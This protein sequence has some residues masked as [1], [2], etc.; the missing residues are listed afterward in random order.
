M[1]RLIRWVIS[2]ALDA[3]VPQVSEGPAHSTLRNDAHSRT[4]LYELSVDKNFIALLKLIVED[5]KPGAMEV[6]RQCVYNKDWHGAATQTGIIAF[7]EELPSTFKLLGD[8]Y[9]P[10]STKV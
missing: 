10:D 5:Q 3:G 4:L 6:L 2:W 8:R 7:L 1:K 9:R